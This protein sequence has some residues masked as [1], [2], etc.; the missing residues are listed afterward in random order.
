MLSL[1]QK[2]DFLVYCLI[3][4]HLMSGYG[5]PWWDDHALEKPH[6]GLED[7]LD[8]HSDPISLK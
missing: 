2:T 5:A 6:F 4:I 7:I 8:H 3:G 1:G